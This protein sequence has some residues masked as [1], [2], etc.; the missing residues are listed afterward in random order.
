M[1]QNP[2]SIPASPESRHSY[3]RLVRD[4][5]VE[6][7]NPVPEADL[8]EDAGKLAVLSAVNKSR[9]PLKRLNKTSPEV[10]RLKGIEDPEGAEDE[11]ARRTLLMREIEADAV[12]YMGAISKLQQGSPS[13]D[14][15]LERNFFGRQLPVI[16]LAVDLGLM[17][18]KP[19]YEEFWSFDQK[20][21]AD[22]VTE[23]I[24]GDP[25]LLAEDALARAQYLQERGFN[26]PFSSGD[27][28]PNQS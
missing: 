10:L 5:G 20:V 15:I 24:F 7:I 8:H 25:S 17:V 9:Y 11:Y 22:K 16:Q 1:T 19:N 3:L 13:S 21:I 18:K 26:Y 6:L 14:D 2:I 4:Q 27:N 28:S 12:S 23:W